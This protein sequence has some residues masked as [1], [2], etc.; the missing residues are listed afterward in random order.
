MAKIKFENL[1]EAV[2]VTNNSV[3]TEKVY[4]IAA[5]VK[6]YE[7]NNVSSVNGGRVEKDGKIVCTFSTYSQ[8]QMNANFQN[9]S[10]VME[11]CAILQS[12]NTFVQD[13]TT[14]VGEGTAIAIVE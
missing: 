1:T 3:D 2:I 7:S 11:M 10:D 12:I 5:N 8:G 9:V 14:E 13:V 6:I 4:D